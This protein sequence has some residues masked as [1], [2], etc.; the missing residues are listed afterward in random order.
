MRIDGKDNVKQRIKV[1][2]NDRYI[3]YLY[4][5]ENGNKYTDTV[6]KWK[7]K[8]FKNNIC[9]TEEEKIESQ[10]DKMVHRR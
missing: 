4:I 2:E 1:F 6:S 3:T 8:D 10:L 7:Q 9:K 5:F